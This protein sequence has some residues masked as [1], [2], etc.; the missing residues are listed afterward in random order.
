[1]AA[2]EYP[3][4]LAEFADLL[5]IKSA[6]FLMDRGIETSGQG[7]GRILVKDLRPPLWTAQ[8]QLVPQPRDT[9]AAIMAKLETLESYGGTFEF[10]DPR[11][12]LPI[13]G[14]VN[15]DSVEILALGG[16]GM[17]LSLKG[18]VHGSTISEGDMLSYLYGGD[19][20]TDPSL[21]LHR[22]SQTVI[23]DGSGH[24]ATF[25]ISP[26]LPV[27][28]AINE[29]VA[30]LK[31]RCYM[32]IVPKSATLEQQDTLLDVVSFSALQVI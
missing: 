25:Q 26:G 24:T 28:V 10:Y 17:S 5:P 6:P 9:A 29:P 20:G 19:T 12:K 22:V 14:D 3:L 18:C 31:P 27:G 32:M 16:D 11:R 15:D 1:M 13:A 2:I 23:A 30:L 7:S 8:V 4:S 21:A